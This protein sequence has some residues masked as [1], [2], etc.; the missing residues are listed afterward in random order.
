[1]LRRP[2]IKKR[3]RTGPSPREEVDEGD[4]V[5]NVE[6][7]LEDRYAFPVDPHPQP[8][9]ATVVF[10]AT[11]VLVILMRNELMLKLPSHTY[12]HHTVALLCF[13]VFKLEYG[14][15]SLGN[16]LRKTSSQ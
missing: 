2:R 9:V 3:K 1:M 11:D 10:L 14:P 16:G 12:R 15:D 5:D 4:N 13:D 8:G 7:A 6:D